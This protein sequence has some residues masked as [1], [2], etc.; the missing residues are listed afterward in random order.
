MQ[1]LEL[2]TVKAVLLPAQRNNMTA[3]T[4]EEINKLAQDPDYGEDFLECYMNHLNLMSGNVARSHDSYVRALKF[5]TLVESGHKLVD[6]YIKT[7]PERYQAKGENCDPDS[8]QAH[9]DMMRSEASRYNRTKIVNEIRKAATVPVQ[10]IHRHVLHEAILE[11]A[12]L[13]RNA[14]SEFVRQAA[15]ACLIKELKPSEEH[16][17]SVHV[18]DGTKSVIEDLRR[19]TEE[20]AKVQREKVV[21]GSLNLKDVAEAIIITKE[22]ED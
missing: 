21:N 15:A 9:K 18:E 3:E 20:L 13:M 17:V 4:I 2:A 8:E 1:K 19:V 7:F 5:F 14:K 10:L 6:A 22:V 12:E 11:Q 16:V